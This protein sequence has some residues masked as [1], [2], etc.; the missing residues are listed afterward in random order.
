[1]SITKEKAIEIGKKVLTDINYSSADLK[2]PSAR[3]EEG[4]NLKYTSKSSAF[5]LVSFSYGAE[6]FGPN[7][8]HVHIDIDAE[9]GEVTPS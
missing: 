6:D 7:V 3:L 1:M 8:A 9:T 5:W 4:E 2:K